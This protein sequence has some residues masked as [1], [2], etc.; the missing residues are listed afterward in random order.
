MTEP[1]RRPDKMIADKMVNGQNGIG[2]NGMDKMI[3]MFCMDLN[4][5]EFNLY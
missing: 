1:P 2:Q 4:S 3:T 5:I